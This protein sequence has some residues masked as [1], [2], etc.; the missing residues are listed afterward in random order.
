M[1]KLNGKVNASLCEKT[2]NINL[3]FELLKPEKIKLM[4]KEYTIDKL[5]FNIKE[6]LLQV[7]FATSKNE[8]ITGD[9]RVKKSTIKEAIKIVEASDEKFKNEK[10]IEYI[11]EV[12]KREVEKDYV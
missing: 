2:N 9:L 4:S 11:I 12:L 10:D 1:A 5:I 7:D 8:K 6:D 3:N